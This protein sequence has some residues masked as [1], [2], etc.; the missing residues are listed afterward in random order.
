[1]FYFFSMPK[2]KKSLAPK[3]AD[4]PLVL[5]K[6]DDNSWDREADV[7]VVGFGGAGACAALEAKAQGARV[8]VL[9]RFHGGGATAISGGVF[10]A[11]GGTHIQREAG[12]D[13]DAEAMFRYLS[14]EVKGVVSEET[15]RDFCDR[16][17]E[18]LG[19]L[20]GHGVPFEGSLCPYKTSYPTDDYYLYYSGNEGFSPY[21]DAAK[22]APRGHRAK[23]TGLPGESFYEPLRASAVRAGIDVEYE[24]RVTRLVIDSSHQVLGVEYRKIKRGFWSQLHRKLHQA[25]IA[26]VKYNPKLAVKLRKRCF[27]IEAEHSVVTRARALNGV[28]LAAGGFI[29]NRG[30]VKEIAPNYRAGMPLGTASDN[31]SGILLGQS[32]G[33]KTDLMDRISAWRF[34]NPPEAF[35]KGM[36]I[37]KKGERYINEFMYGAAVGE[38]MVEENDGE[39]IVIINAELKKLAREQCKPGRA[40]WF[41]RA[42]ALLNLWFNTKEASSIE[43]LAK[44]TKVP[45]D[46]LQKTLDEY[47]DA[48]DGKTADRFGKDADKMHAMRSGP[49]Y[50]INAGIRS[51]RFPCPTL[52]LGGLVVD[53]GTGQVKGESGSVIPGLYAAGRN[54][55]GVCSRQYV[56]GLS[57]ADCVYSGRRAGGAAARGEVY[58]ASDAPAPTQTPP[59]EAKA[60][61]EEIPAIREAQVSDP[62]PEAH[63]G[64]T[65]RARRE[66]PYPRQALN[67][68]IR[69]PG[70]TTRVSSQR[71]RLAKRAP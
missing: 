40:Q 32:V 30:M 52:T 11:G 62:A 15:L 16:S 42:P 56:S 51:K 37:N 35:A 63:Q 6:S 71:G 8:L 17:V 31:G 26:I 4:P 47:N 67:R 68:T 29:Y 19:W 45:A 69:R 22:P 12:V 57:I 65:R 25:G 9:D 2:G 39:A 54:A 38:A 60:P 21:K 1:M 49:Y 70:G 41:Q 44:I 61:I 64:P 33:A 20:E 5:T 14:L 34:I 36:I 46:A 58:A 7:I 27:Q 10:Y 53:E 28:I 3:P 48:A 23:G 24:A 43:E 13:D 55:V 59:I 50:A 18:N 66:G